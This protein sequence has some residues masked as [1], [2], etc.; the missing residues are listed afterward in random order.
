MIQ[1]LQEIG[2]N[3]KSLNQQEQKTKCPNCLRIGKTH[4]N[5]LCLA[6]N[7]QKGVYYCHKCGWTGQVRSKEMESL[8]KVPTKSNLQ[9]LTKE[10]RGVFK[11][12]RYY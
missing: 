4:Y 7:I 10:G 5:D 9:K 11:F 1:E 6:V 12:T 2:I 3:I 8:Y